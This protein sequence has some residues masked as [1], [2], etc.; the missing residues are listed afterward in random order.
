[1][2]EDQS[3][4]GR[5]VAAGRPAGRLKAKLADVARLAG[6]GSATVDRVLN[7]RGN[8]APETARK[9]ID[10]ARQLKLPRSLPVPYRRGLRLDVI[11]TRPETPFF[12]RLNRAFIRV[13]ATLDHSVI[14]QRS[15]VDESKPRQVAERIL[16]TNGHAIV[17]YGQ[18]DPAVIEA[19][20]TVTAGGIP[21][22]AIVSDLPTSPRLAY[23][24][25]NHYSAGRTAAF[26][27]A[28][29]APRAGPVLALCH[30]F[31]YRAHAD[32]ISGFRDGLVDHNPDLVLGDILQGR[33]EQVLSERL[34]AEALRRS[35]GTVGIYN[36]GGA[37][38]AVERALAARGLAGQAVF[39]GHELN[40]H[41]ARMLA[42]G[43][44]TLAIDQ[45]PEEQARR[46]IELLLRRFGYH[47]TAGEPNEVPFTI[48]SPENLVDRPDSESPPPPRR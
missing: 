22:V 48:Y 16:A 39:I 11:L 23:V 17:I 21:V 26:F 4:P 29:L 18:E 44:M 14:V 10:A 19:A 2:N 15:F 42:D 45:N 13:A 47:D 32:R 34:V 24:G 46:A 8:V 40:L 27:M 9:V 36:A 7:E 12:E 31:Q 35:A 6:V 1:M 20:A 25:I 43:V 5:G 37:N 28:R 38:R 41:S 3:K 33:D 30:S